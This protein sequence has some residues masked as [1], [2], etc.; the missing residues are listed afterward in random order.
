[1]QDLRK[2]AKQLQAA[3]RG[4]DRILAHITP[5]EAA[6]LKRQGGAGTI[7]PVTG[8]PEYGNIF[9]DLWRG[10]KKIVKAVAPLILPVVAIFA[11]QVLIGIGTTLGASAAMA[12][13]VGAGVLS[14]GVTLASGGTFKQALTSGLITAGSA[15]FAPIIG[16]AITP[17]GTSAALQSIAGTAAITGGLTALRGGT[18][19]QVLTAAATGAAGAYL[20]QVA[21]SAFAKI[22]NGMQS[23]S[24]EKVQQQPAEDAVFIA[25][26]AENLAKA[27]LSQAQI[28]S[29]LKATG[30]NAGAA[31]VAA[32][33]ASQGVA[34]DNIAYNVAARYGNVNKLYAT[35]GNTSSITAGN[36]LEVLQRAE[37][38]MIIAED[39]IRLRDQGLGQGAIKDTLIASGVDPEVANLAAQR[40]VQPNATTQT[41]SEQ[42]G[43]RYSNR[44]LMNDEA[45]KI[46][47]RAIGTKL[48]AEQARELYTAEVD[49]KL[50]AR[51]GQQVAED[52]AFAAADAKQLAA[53]G[54]SQT[55]IQQTLQ[56]SGLETNAAT[57]AARMAFTGSDFAS[58]TANL[59]QGVSAGRPLYAAQQPV[60]PVEPAQPAQPSAP[61]VPASQQQTLP[62]GMTAEQ[63]ADFEFAAA[64]AAQLKAQG[65][66]SNQ[67]SQTLQAAGVDP[68]I[69]RQMAYY[70]DI[71]VP[72]DQ[73]ARTTA[74]QYS[75]RSVFNDTAAAGTAT[76]TATGTTGTTAPSQPTLTPEQQARLA[77]A[78]FLAADA[79]QLRAQGLSQDQIQTTLVQSGA[80][81]NAAYIA[82]QGAVRGQS[83][84][85]IVA[86]L[87]TV[88]G[89]L[90]T[91]PAAPAQPAQPAQPA[92]AA[93]APAPAQPTITPEQQ[94][95]LDDAAFLA[96]DA[97][98]LRAQGLSQDQIQT[99]LV[100]SGAS[101]NAA[102]VASLGAVRG[103]SADQIVA[104]LGS[105]RGDLIISAPAAPVQPP[106]S[107][108]IDTTD[109]VPDVI[110]D[111][112]DT[113]G[114]Q[115][116]T[117]AGTVIEPVAP[118][119]NVVDSGVT[120]VS[121]QPTAQPPV[122]ETLPEVVVSANPADVT[123]SEFL[124]ADAA[125]LAAQGLSPSQ[126]EQ[127]LIY[128]GAQPDIAADLANLAT[129][130]L[131]PPQIADIID[132]Q[133]GGLAPWMGPEFRPVQ[134]GANEYVYQYTP[135]PG[136]FYTY[137]GTVADAGQIARAQQSLLGVQ[138]VTFPG[139]PQQLP[140]E[141]DNSFVAADAAQLAA[142]GLG[143]DQIQQVLEY[144]GVDP[145]V[146][147]D[148]ANL[149][150]QGLTAET[151]QQNLDQTTAG[152]GAPPT[153][154]PPPPAAEQPVEPP[155]QPV[156]EPPADLG[157]GIDITKLPPGEGYDLVG[158][159]PL[160]PD[161]GGGTG[162]TPPI[163]PALP[164]M[165]GGTGVVVP[166]VTP[167]TDFVPLEPTFPPS[168]PPG[169]GLPPEVVG[170]IV[171]DP[172]I[173]DIVEEPPPATRP[174]SGTFTPAPPDPSWSIPLQYPGLNLGLI[175]AGIR[176]AYT[177]TSPVQSQYY[178]GR[179]PYM[180]YQEDLDFYN[181]VPMPA[182]PWGQQQAWWEQPLNY[183]GTPVYNENLE[184]IPQV[185]YG[186]YEMPPAP[187]VATRAPLTRTGSI[188]MAPVM[189][190]YTLPA[191]PNYVY[192]IAP[193]P[194]Q[195]TTG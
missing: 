194:D 39:A 101:Q 7:N 174:P 2:A 132:Q 155:Q 180:A 193:T 142:Q 105:V 50:V 92:A 44:T 97:A 124:A 69:A 88:R 48:T 9:S 29:T 173:R 47:D 12:P 55:Q 18:V 175:G 79:A 45:V 110:E 3:G 183:Q 170:P 71:G 72:A 34:A 82:A 58:I 108:T 59:A 149:A 156:G 15:Y 126:V 131:A 191:A 136:L 195:Y 114:M 80:S 179:Q 143:Q 161:M 27:G 123:D 90:I 53:Q 25:A 141:T 102:Y 125:Q 11:P 148:A 31:E 51:Y 184:Q 78:E 76:G 164:D 178:W 120:Q 17:G 52:L 129:S 28:A 30:A 33:L 89:D 8:L 166:G 168:Q 113:T 107:D 146:A 109:L 137:Q 87:G 128:S 187:P 167:P 116:D 190:S 86:N 38:S 171:A 65:L 70:A 74:G 60:Q 189:P 49:P 40:A 145:F 68:S 159:S 165:G 185:R 22:N 176:P 36:N 21:S 106:A 98:Q 118:P 63:F 61:P 24:I 4:D 121:D 19:S 172:I 67:I 152:P 111:V 139:A 54:L 46:E 138:G 56:S 73:I 95:R 158:T 100:Q 134:I 20:G 154:V 181:Q 177:T 77:D 62:Q 1:M 119:T 103:Q 112:T 99:T 85:Q 127:N 6:L 13:I 140:P 35:T 37:D 135:E 169:E 160:P 122:V 42:L 26:D 133:Y 94:A 144:S 150:S 66:G 93:P 115:P 130:G 10:F 104:S 151:I 182:Q 163:Y 192:S 5:E 75:T 81:Q 188:P 186:L 14:A 91:A 157:G 43:G 16:K 57:N 162:I 41:V 64:D 84:D 32:S 153:F 83:A 147:A 117:G 23:G 96:A